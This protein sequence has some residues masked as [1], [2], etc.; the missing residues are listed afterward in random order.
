MKLE[1]PGVAVPIE[2]DRG[3]NRQNIHFSIT[4]FAKLTV[5]LGQVL[6][7][8]GGW[9]LAQLLWEVVPAPNLPEFRSAWTTLLVRWFSCRYSCEE[10]G[11]GLSH[12]GLFPNPEILWFYDLTSPFL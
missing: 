5:F 1:I 4:V 12:H 7:L 8:E 10:Q 2:A 11:A 9:A 3:G 6:H